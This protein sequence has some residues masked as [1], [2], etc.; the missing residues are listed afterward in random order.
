MVERRPP[1]AGVRGIREFMLHAAT[2]LSGPIGEG[3][4]TIP[5][6][7]SMVDAAYVL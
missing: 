3:P 7:G 2:S 4:G 6:G 5:R 1:R